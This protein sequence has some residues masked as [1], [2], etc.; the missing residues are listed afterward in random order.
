MEPYV[1]VSRVTEI[2]GFVISYFLFRAEMGVAKAERPLI[3]LFLVVVL[4]CLVLC[5]S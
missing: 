4:L 3:N 5:F 2:G 1:A